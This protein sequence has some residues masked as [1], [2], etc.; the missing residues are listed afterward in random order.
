MLFKILKYDL[1]YGKKSFLGLAASLISASIII[2]FLVTA[3]DSP[4][5][6]LVGT[7]LVFG[8]LNL[9]VGIMS[10]VLIYQGFAK[11]FFKNHG[12]LIFTLPV[13]HSVLLIS[14]VITS[15]IWLNFMIVVGTISSYILNFGHE[16]TAIVFEELDIVGIFAWIHYNVFGLFAISVFFLIITLSHC[17]IKKFHINFVLASIAGVLYFV[18]WAQ[19]LQLFYNIVD[20]GEIGIGVG[21]FNNLFTGESSYLVIYDFVLLSSATLFSIL[22]LFLILKL[23]KYLEIR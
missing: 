15:I 16:D 1:L 17:Y 5:V 22:A 20:F 21:T 23:F 18:I 7:Y 13:K 12:Y 11:S 19:I 4:L 6:P 8:F 9:L 2:R 3:F 10:I 14:K